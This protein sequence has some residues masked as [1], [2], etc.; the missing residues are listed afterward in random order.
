MSKTYLG[1]FFAYKAKNLPGS[2]FWADID[3]MNIDGKW[4][5]VDETTMI[6]YWKSMKITENHWDSIKEIIFGT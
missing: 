3:F 2:G 1:K 4:M 6:N 5:I